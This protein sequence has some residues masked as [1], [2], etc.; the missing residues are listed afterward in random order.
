MV[1]S[2]GRIAFAVVSL[3]LLFGAGTAQA[4][5]PQPE[6]PGFGM[7]GITEVQAQIPWGLAP[8]SSLLDDLLSAAE[9]DC[10]SG[11]RLG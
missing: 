6:P 1:R 4:F 2:T 9:L 11:S 7:F 3:L 5:N 8:R 10:L